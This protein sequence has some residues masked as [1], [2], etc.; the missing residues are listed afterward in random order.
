VL[1]LA[2]QPLRNAD[3][4]HFG[5]TLELSELPDNL[6]LPESV[7]LEFLGCLCRIDM[8]R[9]RIMQCK[10]TRKDV[11]HDPKSAIR[12]PETFA[13]FVTILSA[14]GVFVQTAQRKPVQ[15]VFTCEYAGSIGPPKH[16]TYVCV[17][18]QS[19]LVHER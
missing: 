14:P 9:K 5:A 1:G 2:P 15:S 6:F 13:V 10:L 17:S 19:E 7:V 8:R 4:E 12:I 18:S 3:I 11:H 16:G